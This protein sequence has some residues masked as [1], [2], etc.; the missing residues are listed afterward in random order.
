VVIEFLRQDGTPA[1]P[2]ETAEV[3]VTTLNNFAMPLIRYRVGDSAAFR[4]GTCRCGVNLPLM[5]LK[6]GK[7]VEL[8]RT[9]SH[10]DVSAHVLDYIN[11]HLMKDGIRGIRQFFV[12][13]TGVDTF[14]LDYIREEPFDGESVLTFQRKMREHLGSQI[15]IDTQEVQSIPLLPSGKRRYFRSSLG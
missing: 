14:R 12:E 11:I 1:D 10:A 4:E 9:S 8:I 7:S 13:Q 15:E 3:V 6:I 5:D 2:E